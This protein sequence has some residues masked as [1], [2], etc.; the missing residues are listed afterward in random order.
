[1][2]HPHADI[3]DAYL[4][5]AE[6]ECYD[7]STN[8]WAPTNNPAFEP[9]LKYRIKPQ[10]TPWYENIPTQGV[11]CWVSGTTENPNSENLMRVIKKYK[12]YGF[13]E[14]DS[15]FTE[16]WRYATPLTNDEIR[17]FLRGEQ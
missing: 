3:I 9:E 12:N 16:V 15:L 17:Q 11:L 13:I 4:E 2:R 5:G 7:E 14:S 10:E 6:I 8:A 1:M